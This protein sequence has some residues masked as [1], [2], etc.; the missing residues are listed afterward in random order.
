MLVRARRGA[1]SRK[2]GTWENSSII[3]NKMREMDATGLGK[4]VQLKAAKKK[5]IHVL[6]VWIKEGPDVLGASTA[7]GPVDHPS[8]TYHEV[9]SVRPGAWDT[10]R[11]QAWLLLSGS[12][13]WTAHEL[14]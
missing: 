3:M 12:L 2:R 13:Q 6:S 5:N 8:H 11:T 14:M 7:L 4:C 10:E 1:W 9:S